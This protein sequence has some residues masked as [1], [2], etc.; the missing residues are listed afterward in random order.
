M[1]FILLFCLLIE[2]SLI[3]DLD[4]IHRYRRHCF[5]EVVESIGL[6]KVELILDKVRGSNCPEK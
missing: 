5:Y 6:C 2:S 1:T 4:A 3:N